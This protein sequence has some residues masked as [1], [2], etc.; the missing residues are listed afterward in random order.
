VTRRWYRRLRFSIRPS[1]E[2][3]TEAQ[4]DLRDGLLEARADRIAELLRINAEL[5]RELA[6]YKAV[7]FMQHALRLRRRQAEAATAVIPRPRRSR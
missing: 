1:D 3:V 6:T 5:T 2:L 7:E 4:I